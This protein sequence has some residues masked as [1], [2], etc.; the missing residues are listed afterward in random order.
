MTISL[1][2]SRNNSIFYSLSHSIASLTHFLTTLEMR[3]FF[4]FFFFNIPIASIDTYIYRWGMKYLEPYFWKF[5]TKG[6]LRIH[7]W[8]GNTLQKKKKRLFTRVK[9]LEISIKNLR[10]KLFRLSRRPL[11]GVNRNTSK[12]MFRRPTQRLKKVFY[13]YRRS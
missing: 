11:E 5:R 13:L 12:K 10:N 2:F 7:A 3:Y 4:F 8:N 9:T 6:S 1:T